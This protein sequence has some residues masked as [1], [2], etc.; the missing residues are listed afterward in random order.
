MQ[1][2]RGIAFVYILV[3]LTMSAY[4]SKE[5]EAINILQTALN[6]DGPFTV[7]LLSGGLMVLL[8][9][10]RPLDFPIL[11]NTLNQVFKVRKTH[12][13]P[14]KLE[15]PPADWQRPYL[16]LA[17]ECNLSL[18]MQEAFLEVADI[19]E[20]MNSSAKAEVQS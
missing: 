5:I 14:L 16:E 11:K 2:T 3:G 18:S 13:V 4:A 8:G 9:R 20:K 6:T 7:E 10:M 17:E 19:Y 1:L 15:R 12:L